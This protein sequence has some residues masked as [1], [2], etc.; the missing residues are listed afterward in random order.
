MIWFLL[1]GNRKKFKVI[2]VVQSLSHVWLF[3]TPWTAA[4]QTSLSFTI[5]LSLLKLMSIELV[6][7]S[8]HLILCHLLLLQSFP[9]F[10]MSQLFTSGGQSIGVSAS[11]SVLP[12]NIQSW[13]PWG[14]TSLISLLFKELSR[15]FS[16]TTIESINSLVF[17]LLYGPA[18]TSI[19]DYWKNRSFDYMDICWQSDVLFFLLNYNC[20]TEFFCFL[21]DLNMNRP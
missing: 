17:S 1:L 7:P 18:L 5:S 14:L 20:F 6:M 13:C 2:V 4:F 10:P 9:S 3:V 12:V 19:H 8:N 16:S 11:A 15:V 21:S